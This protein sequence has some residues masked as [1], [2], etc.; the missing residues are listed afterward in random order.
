MTLPDTPDLV[1]TAATRLSVTETLARSKPANKAQERFR[2]LVTQIER[3]RER[4]QQWQ[5]Y[6]QRYNQRVSGE[7]G[8]LQAKLRTARKQMAL[9]LD[10]LLSV[11]APGRRLGRVQREKLRL[12]LTQLLEHLLQEGDDEDL[13]TLQDK[14]RE[15]LD[16]EDQLLR[17]EM[18]REILQG[19]TGL[20]IDDDHGA[21]SP[22]ELMEYVQRTMQEQS[23]NAHHAQEQQ[24]RRSREDSS[25]DR[26]SAEQS[27]R[28]QAARQVSQ[29]LRDVFR[30]LVSALHPDREPD[31]VERQRKN[32]LMQ[33]VNRAYD[34]NDLLTLLGLQLEI[35]QIDAAHLSSLTPQRLAQ[36]TQ[37]LREQL[38]NLET[39][40]AHFVQPFV[41]AMGG[42][43]R[44]N[45]LNPSDVD[46]ALSLDLAQ[47]RATLHQLQ[48][49]LVAFRDPV[50][51]RRRLAEAEM[52]S[53]DPFDDLEEIAELMGGFQPAPRRR[54]SRR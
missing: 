43:R 26:T 16:E 41:V 21:R 8:P 36:Y 44:D 7:L 50:R 9:L 12:L 23:E 38:A 22:E 27:E 40:L 11:P 47:M 34:A 46:R 28:G 15:P 49:D 51:L 35:E 31:P 4:L 18:T 6:A 1:G 29:S 10:E 48:E 3:Q 45:R 33:R 13:T 30:K 14:Y 54:R 17:M 37:I 32:E 52:R 25:K 19:M 5:D 42:G 53:S 2:K 24:R 39:E 20:E